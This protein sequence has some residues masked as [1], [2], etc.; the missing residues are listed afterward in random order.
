MKFPEEYFRGGVEPEDL[1]ALFPLL[2]A[3]AALGAFTALFRGTDEDVLIRLLV[4]REIGR[5]GE[6]PVWSPQELQIHFAYLDETKLQ[7]VLHRLRDTG[8]LVWN[9]ESSN[10][11]ISPHGR[12]A[13]S[14]LSILLKFSE[15]EDGEIGYITSQLAAGQSLGKVSDEDLQHL[16]SRLNELEAEFGRAV[17]SGSELRIRSAEKKL[18]SVLKW[19]EKGTEIMKLIAGSPDLDQ[20]THRVAQKIGQV[21]SRMLRMSSVFQRTLNQLE[22]QKVHLGQSGLST[23][24]IHGWLRM[25]DRDE[26]CAL[27]DE[28]MTFPARIAC[29]LGDIAL[30]IAEFELVDRVRAEAE[31]TV[32]PPP[33]E[34]PPAEKMPVMDEDLVLLGNLVGELE[35]IEAEAPLETTIPA[36]D[37]ATTSYRF[38]LAALLGDPDSSTLGG[39]VADLTRLPLVMNLTG[40]SV[41]VGRCEVETMSAGS[42]K[43]KEG[44]NGVEDGKRSSGTG[45]ETAGQTT[46]AARK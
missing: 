17:L 13:L 28:A 38:S 20:P 26:I 46:S 2:R 3:H 35:R 22:R 12:M 16:L 41:E 30:D 40:A 29:L 43:N 19:V 10:Y 15:E 18:T 21:Q 5:R 27:F 1:P 36:V 24:D 32:L 23:S 7:T 45:R 14:A 11:Q 9:Q 31:D 33:C 34:A 42:V 39:K 25:L 37:F 4:L 44:E 8:L 6:Q